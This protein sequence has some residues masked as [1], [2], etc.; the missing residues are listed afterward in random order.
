MSRLVAGPYE[1]IVKVSAERFVSSDHGI[2]VGTGNDPASGHLEGR[3]IAPLRWE[4]AGVVERVGDCVT[5]FAAGDE[6][7]GCCSV[8][9]MRVSDSRF[10]FS[11]DALA[12]KPRRLSLKQAATVPAGVQIAWEAIGNAGALWN[13]DVLIAGARSGAAPW[14]VQLAR[15][16]GANACVLCTEEESAYA[17]TWGASE[18]ISSVP[19]QR[20]KSQLEGRSFS[21]IFHFGGPHGPGDLFPALGKGGR[22]LTTA[23][24][25]P[26]AYDLQIFSLHWRPSASVLCHVATL[27]DD[28]TLRLPR[29]VPKPARR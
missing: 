26:S 15:H 25:G 20:G 3:T 18:V 8:S 12:L 7:Y 13:E 9:D 17:V 28:G 22:F 21:R 14:L 23:G 1:V 27:I 6:V 4:G 16:R 5:L 29:A 19:S 11:Q 10:A 2:E 24:Y